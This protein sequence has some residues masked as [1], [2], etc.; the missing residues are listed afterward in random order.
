MTIRAEHE[1]HRRRLGRNLGV[2]LTL[3]AS[4]SWS[5]A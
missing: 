3:A 1:I 2:G 5:S 4:S